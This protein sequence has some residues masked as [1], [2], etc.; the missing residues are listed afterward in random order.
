M[1]N[2]ILFYAFILS[3]VYTLRFIGEFL[4]KMFQ[5]EPTPM[6]LSKVNEIIL[7]FSVSYIIAFPFIHYFIL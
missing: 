7:Y 5:E 1:I 6:E 4:F 3:I 2:A